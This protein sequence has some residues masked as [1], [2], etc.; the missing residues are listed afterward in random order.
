MISTATL[1]AIWRIPFFSAF[2]LFGL[3]I[4]PQS[5]EV[6]PRKDGQ[7]PPLRKVEVVGPLEVSEFSISCSHLG[8]AFTGLAVR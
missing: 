2:S 1:A 3:L 7:D 4:T 8:A 6:R 5:Q